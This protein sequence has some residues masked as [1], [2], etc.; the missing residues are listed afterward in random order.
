MSDT[1]RVRAWRERLK[2]AGLVP[3]TIWVRTETKA[4]YEDLALQRHRSPSELVQLALDAYRLDPATVAAT[5]TDIEQIRTI[6]REEID[7][8]TPGITATLTATVTET[9]MAMLPALVQT[10]VLSV[11]SDAETETV[12][13]T[14]ES[15]VHAASQD[16]VPDAVTDTATDTMPTPH[17][18]RA[19]PPTTAYDPDAAY[20]RMQTLHAQGQTLAQIAAQLTAEGI[21]TRHGQPWHKS[22]VAYLLKTHS[23]APARR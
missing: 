22:T 7:H 4:R 8:M 17:G 2:Q 5:V 16:A 15:M 10:A 21:R 3:M 19:A 1:D 12:T 14:T 20:A 11:V 13:A 9:L 18:R 6:I 23:A